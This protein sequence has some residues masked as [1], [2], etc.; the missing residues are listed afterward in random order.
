MRNVFNDDRDGAQRKRRRPEKLLQQ[1]AAAR[2]HRPG[3]DPRRDRVA[4]LAHHVDVR[5]RGLGLHRIP[6]HQPSG[7]IH[8]LHAH[9]VDAGEYTRRIFFFQTTA[10]IDRESKFTTISRGIGEISERNG[11]IFP[12]A[13]RRKIER[14]KVDALLKI[15][16][17]PEN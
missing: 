5:L 17:F 15:S 7:Q 16:Y 3:G 14:I 9:H 12:R 11:R 8:V 4:V 1:P 6:V 10:C 2:G 13:K